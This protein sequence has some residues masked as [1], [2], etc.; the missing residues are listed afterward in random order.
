MSCSGRATASRPLR[1]T[2]YGVT[3][4]SQLPL[5]E[6][7]HAPQA[8]TAQAIRFSLRRERFSGPYRQVMSWALPTGAPWLSCNQCEGGYVLRFAELADFGV[9]QH[10]SEITA[11]PLRELAPETLSHLLLDHVLPLVLNLRGQDALHATAVLT[12]YGVC[13][14]TGPAGMGKSTLAAAFHRAGDAIF[15]DDCL[16]L[17]PHRQGLTAIPAYPGL[18]LWQDSLAALGAAGRPTQAV[19]HYTSKQRLATPNRLGHAPAAPHRLAAIYALRRRPAEPAPRP[20]QSETLSRRDAL[21]EL[22][23]HVF[24]M[25]VTDRNMLARQLDWLTQL[26]ASAPVHRLHYASSFDALD[27][28]RDAILSDLQ[29]APRHRQAPF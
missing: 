9:D 27:P 4:L 6:L 8:D 12:P 18:R 23:P 5:P 11:R 3:L 28:V 15:S 7:A 21:M 2:V 10:G 1:Y 24:R 29:Q 19:A 13:A 14:F 16:A 17:Q 25:D 22:L 26:V 20:A